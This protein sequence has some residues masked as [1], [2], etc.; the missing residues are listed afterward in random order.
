MIAYFSLLNFFFSTCIYYIA[1]IAEVLL[2]SVNSSR[3]MYVMHTY[4]NIYI[5]LCTCYGCMYQSPCSPWLY[6]MWVVQVINI[7]TLC[8]MT[9]VLLKLRFTVMERLIYRLLKL[10]FFIYKYAG[11]LQYIL[12][13]GC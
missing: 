2:V 12:P 7:R 4:D 11:I 5:G 3:T 8:H 13:S 6:N 1:I 10:L 9:Q